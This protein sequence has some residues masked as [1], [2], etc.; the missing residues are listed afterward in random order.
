LNP[1]FNG[2]RVS[3]PEVYRN[4]RLRDRPLVNSRWELVFNQR[5][6]LVNQ[7]ININALNDIRLYFYYSDF[8]A[9]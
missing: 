5:D 9:F 2:Q 4:A 6:E 7:D 8:T 3:A 1:F